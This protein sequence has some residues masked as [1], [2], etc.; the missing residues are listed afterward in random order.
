MLKAFRTV[1]AGSSARNVLFVRL[2]HSPV[3]YGG[4]KAYPNPSARFGG[5]VLFSLR[6]IF[7]V[8]SSINVAASHIY[9]KGAIINEKHHQSGWIH[10]DRNRCR[11]RDNRGTY[12]NAASGSPEV[13]LKS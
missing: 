5:L 2:W 1:V 12:R 6:K 4:V 11:D 10:V 3:V 8:P 7:L 9:T 13:N